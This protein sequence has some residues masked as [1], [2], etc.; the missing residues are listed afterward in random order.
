[1]SYVR[2]SA[3]GYPESR[4]PAN[5]APPRAGDNS[6]QGQQRG[7]RQQSVCMDFL[8]LLGSVGTRRYTDEGV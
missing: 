3:Q 6:A 2:E 5:E 7:A 4:T 8:L 1:M